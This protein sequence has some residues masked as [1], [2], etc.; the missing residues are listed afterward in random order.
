[1]CGSQ[2]ILEGIYAR[3]HRLQVRNPQPSYLRTRPAYSPLCRPPNCWPAS[4]L[5]PPPPPV[6]QCSLPPSPST[7]PPHAGP[8]VNRA[9]VSVNSPAVNNRAVKAVAANS[10]A[11][12]G[13]AVNK[14]GVNRTVA[15]W[16]RRSEQHGRPSMP[17][18]TRAGE[19]ECTC[20]PPFLPLQS[21]SPPS[22][23]LKALVRHALLVRPPP[24]S[25]HPITL[26]LTE[27]AARAA[28]DAAFEA[29]WRV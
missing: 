20:P 12:N 14:T 25:L 24:S 10:P 1:M 28:F 17:P 19:R 23:E 8:A 22:Y 16:L 21:H 26:P 2:E 5:T 11:V 13:V 27:Q 18:S 7:S 3:G 6:A 4:L 29:N 15:R 9:G